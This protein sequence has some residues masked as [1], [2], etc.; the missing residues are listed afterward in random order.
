MYIQ[1]EKKKPDIKKKKT[2]STVS[3][4]WY[5]LNRWFLSF[6]LFSLF[7]SGYYHLTSTSVN[8]VLIVLPSLSLISSNLQ[9]G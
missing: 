8:R 4:T 3:S 9:S 1:Y 6:I 7:Y 5:E 2:I